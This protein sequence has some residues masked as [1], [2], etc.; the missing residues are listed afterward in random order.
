MLEG[1][2][3]TVTEVAAFGHQIAV[4]SVTPRRTF[5]AVTAGPKAGPANIQD[6]RWS[7]PASE[8]ATMKINVLFSQTAEHQNI[9]DLTNSHFIVTGTVCGLV[10]RNSALPPLLSAAHFALIHCEE[11][12]SSSSQREWTQVSGR[13]SCVDD[14]NATR[15]QDVTGWLRKLVVI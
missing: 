13:K 7:W 1:C 11:L 15:Y 2:K 6:T 5:T 14:P 12:S 10:M 4:K 8:S 3:Y 9:T